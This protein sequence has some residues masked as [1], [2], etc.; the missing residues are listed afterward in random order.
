MSPARMRSPGSVDTRRAT[1]ATDGR[2]HMAM[3]P[4]ATTVAV[5]PLGPPLPPP[6]LEG[7]DGDAHAVAIPRTTISRMASNRYF[8]ALGPALPYVVPFRHPLQQCHLRP[9]RLARLIAW[10]CR[11]RNR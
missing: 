10:S 5:R 11:R 4:A 8:I 9:Q 2:P 7:P 6:P 3:S 1:C